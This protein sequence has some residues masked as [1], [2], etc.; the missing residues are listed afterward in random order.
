[1]FKHFIMIIFLLFVFVSPANALSLSGGG[2]GGSAGPE[3]VLVIDLCDGGV[4]NVSKEIEQ[5]TQKEHENIID[6][7]IP[8]YDDFEE[9]Y[10]DEIRGCFEGI[11]DW[12][13]AFSL[14]GFDF[15]DIW[16]QL[17]DMAW[18]AMDDAGILDYT[19]LNEDYTIDVFGEAIQDSPWFNITEYTFG[20]DVS[21]EDISDDIWEQIEV[22][23]SE[24]GD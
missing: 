3:E 6:E 19:Q 21:S 5:K 16:G 12:G 4:S 7:Y 9:S 10:E 22:D 23:P 2:G 8:S 15:G 24:I 17:C 13:G 18:D 14:I 20:H 11:F 1:M